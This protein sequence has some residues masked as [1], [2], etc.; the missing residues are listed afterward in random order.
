MKLICLGTYST[1]ECVPC[2]TRRPVHPSTRP[3]II[4]PLS[5]QKAVICYSETAP[6]ALQN[7]R[8]VPALCHSSPGLDST[9]K[10]PCQLPPA[11]QSL[12]N[13]PW[14]LESL[15]LESLILES[16]ILES[17]A[18]NSAPA[19]PCRVVLM[20]CLPQVAL[21]TAMRIHCSWCMHSGS[22]VHWPTSL[23]TTLCLAAVPEAPV[24]HSQVLAA[25][26]ACC[27]VTMTVLVPLGGENAV[28]SK[29]NERMDSHCTCK[30]W[31]IWTSIF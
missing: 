15:I 5:C 9:S 14:T 4:F 7:I 16:L 13:R 1:V 6:T 29:G 3:R 30:W 19:A 11:M 21:P 31:P 10:L 18:L 8:L 12:N 22:I 17:S 25:T 27:S 26:L 2:R 20:P 28:S 23:F 24:R